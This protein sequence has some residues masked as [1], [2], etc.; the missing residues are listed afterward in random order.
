M[1]RLLK[2]VPLP[3]APALRSPSW[4]SD[5]RRAKVFSPE[6]SAVFSRDPQASRGRAVTMWMLL[7]V[8]GMGCPT[9]ESFP[10]GGTGGSAGAGPGGSAGAANGGHLGAGGTGGQAGAAGAPVGAAGTG[11]GGAAGGPGGAA[12]S[13]GGAAGA[14]GAG[15]GPGGAVAGTSGGSSGGAAGTGATCTPGCAA[16][17]YCNSGTCTSRVTEFTLQDIGARPAYIALGPDGNLWFT[18]SAYDKIRRISTSGT[19]NE[20]MVPSRGS[21][22]GSITP[23]PDGNVWFGEENT[24]NI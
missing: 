5:A 8:V 24:G 15:G 7:A 23:G 10:G 16:S 22:L 4:R 17:A 3:G 6:A 14:P 12:G 9:R 2:S 13:R 20:F 11:V 19:I 1:R 18:D 21:G